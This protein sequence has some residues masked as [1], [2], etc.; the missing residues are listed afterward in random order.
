MV[1]TGITCYISK[2]VTPDDEKKNKAHSQT[3]L[4]NMVQ[5]RT[6]NNKILN[7]ILDASSQWDK[8]PIIWVSDNIPYKIKLIGKSDN[9]VLLH[10]CAI[11][12][13]YSNSGKET[14]TC[15][16]KRQVKITF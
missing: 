15:I 4:N 13:K 8:S 12:Y 16:S 6:D 10:Q 2:S 5:V 7:A 3:I 14:Y 1:Y 9:H 11:R